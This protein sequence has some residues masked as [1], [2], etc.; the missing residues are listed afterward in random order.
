[1]QL[2]L[3][4][5]QFLALEILCLAQPPAPLQRCCSPL[6][7]L[8]TVTQGGYDNTSSVGRVGVKP[9]MSVAPS[10]LCEQALQFL[11]SDIRDQALLSLLCLLHR[12]KPHPGHPSHFADVFIALPTGSLYHFA[13]AAPVTKANTTDVSFTL[14]ASVSPKNFPVLKLPL[15]LCLQGIVLG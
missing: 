7:L 9:G 13:A 2:G 14:S 11:S 5:I 3:R 10:S 8:Q 12:I 15:L 1:M 4:S 6:P